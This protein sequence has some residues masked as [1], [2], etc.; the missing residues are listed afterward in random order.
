MKTID[1][2]LCAVLLLM[3]AD[4]RIYAADLPP[5]R[6][7]ALP[8]D[9][10][11]E[12]L[13]SRLTLE[14]KITLCGGV[15]MWFIN[16]VP[17]LGLPRVAMADGSTTGVKG[18]FGTGTVLP[19]ALALAATWDREM[20]KAFGT[21]EA[22]DC[23]AVGYQILLGP[24]VN[25]ARNPLLGR[26]TEYFGEDPYL[27]GTMA[28][29]IIRQVQK[30]GIL[31]CIKHFVANDIDLPRTFS[32]SRVD[33]RTLRE[34]YLL[35]FEM[36]VKQ[37]KVATV[38]AAYNHVNGIHACVNRHTLEQILRQEWGFDGLVMSDWG[39]GSGSASVWAMGPLDLAM[40]T[41][42]MGEAKTVL[43]LIQKG[44]ID[45]KVYDVKVRNILRQCF[46]FGLYDRPAKD[47]SLKFGDEAGAQVALQVARQGIVL[48]KNQRDL[49]P[50]DPKKIKSIAV[51]G[52]HSQPV[53]PGVP[54]INGP[55]GSSALD[56]ANPV[57]ILA[58][59]KAAA[60]SDVKL[61]WV[62]DEI[63]T[64]YEQARYEHRTAE[65]KT[66]PGLLA[67]Y[68]KNND[69]AGPP[70]LER[71]EE[72]L[73]CGHRWRYKNWLRELEPFRNLSVRWEGQ[74]R[75]DKSGE[76]RFVKK[77]NLGTTVWL[78][79]EPILDDWPAFAKGHWM[80]ASRGTVRHLEAGKTYALRIE[81]RNDPRVWH[82]VG[83]QFGWGPVDYSASVAAA[84]SCDAAVLCVGYEYM[85]E[86]EGFERTWQLPYGQKELIE[87]VT[88]ANPN[89][90][91][92]LSGG[93]ACETQSWIERTPALL[94]AWY[95]GQ[96][97]GTAVGEILLGRVNPSG[98]LPVTFDR[99]LEENPS[100]ATF[101]A[102]WSKPYPMPVEYG[103]GIFMGYRGYDKAG[104]EPLF[105]FGHGL[106][107]T[108]FAYRNLTI[109]PQEDGSVQVAGEIANTG[110]RA[111]AEVVQLYV[112]DDHAPVARPPRELKGFARVELQPGET[113]PVTF[114]LS[115]RDFSY[116]D[117]KAQ[118][119]TAAPGRFEISLG[120]SSRDLRLRGDY[121]LKK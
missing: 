76:Y 111:G 84:R 56:C 21:V 68:Y 1:R 91:V 83:F 93:G 112:G 31:A 14:E 74:I 58:G 59:L 10:R 27:A 77:S 109:R 49:L 2:V 65:G 25:L 23:R 8:V 18:S 44:Q 13:L 51:L 63:E 41:G 43:P 54:Y 110:R 86:G 61:V 100:T 19:S 62:P 30:Q 79:G 32:D 69:F 11:V 16:G 20:A 103:E 46:R 113:K 67:R 85:T 120:A 82:M 87:Q 64:M 26:N 47:S 24:A 118:A 4:L 106:S 119:W 94:Q 42:P 45:P 48:L 117:V 92:V 12:D 53:R 28:V 57:T 88:Q 6:N 121:E 96:N 71:V 72:H 102:D 39:A 108:T 81:Y 115:R 70:A 34:L 89:T 38:M 95:L 29:E 9:Q 35:P 97:G 17:R 60:G 50:L 99:H 52:P 101:K 73:S 55:S 105:P 37:A 98:K 80:V 5:Y 114:T 116:Y 33:E 22:H 7:P 66:A 78:D 104:T 15:D 40:P 90:V 3:A 107:Y 36:A 75:P